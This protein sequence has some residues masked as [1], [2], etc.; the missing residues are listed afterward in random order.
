MATDSSKTGFASTKFSSLLSFNSDSTLP[1]S[2]DKLAL[3][4]LL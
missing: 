3:V 4:L 1:L 2:G